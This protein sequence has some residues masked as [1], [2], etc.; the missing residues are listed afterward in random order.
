LGGKRAPQHATHLGGGKVVYYQVGVER[1]SRQEAVKLLR[2][3][4]RAGKIIPGKHFRD[5]L[6]AEGLILPD[7]LRV[8]KTGNI[9]QEPECDPKTGDW[10]YR[11][12]GGEVDG[13]WLAIVFCFRATDTAFLI[14]V[15]S[16]EV[17]RK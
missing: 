7:A 6:A 15:F 8:L 9:F 5:E 2:E 1:Q 13:K 3:C 11:V 12:E 16:V 10:K 14:T 17:K 4:L